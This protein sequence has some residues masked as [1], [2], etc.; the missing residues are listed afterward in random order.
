MYFRQLMAS[1]ECAKL[2]AISYTFPLKEK[3]AV[4]FTLHMKNL[5]TVNINAYMNLHKISLFVFKADVS[6]Q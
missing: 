1:T 2:L 6:F 5:S 4:I 3:K